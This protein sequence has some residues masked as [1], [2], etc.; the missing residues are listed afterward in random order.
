LND[1]P[2]LPSYLNIQAVD[3]LNGVEDLNAYLK[4]V[5]KREHDTHNFSGTLGYLR[6]LTEA[7]EM[8]K[9]LPSFSTY[10]SLRN[11]LDK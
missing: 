8:G 4:K 1:I 5:K 10:H 2:K 7:A 11:Y 6:K 9:P 3:Q